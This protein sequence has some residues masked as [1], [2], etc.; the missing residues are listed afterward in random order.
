MSARLRSAALALVAVA[1]VVSVVPGA[2]ATTDV[3]RDRALA[4]VARA[5]H[6]S[7]SSGSLSAFVVARDGKT[8]TTPNSQIAVT[9]ASLMKLATTTTAV[10]KFGPAA[11]F[12]TRAVVPAA[13]DINGVVAGNLTLVGGGDPTFATGA[14]ARKFLTRKTG[15][16][17][18]STVF[19]TKLPTVELLASRVARAGVTRVNGDLVVDNYLF[20][21]SRVQRG[22]RSSYLN[23]SNGGPDVGYIDPLDVDEGYATLKRTSLT[24]SPAMRAGALLKN[25]LKERGVVVTGEVRRARAPS[26]AVELARVTSPPLG[27]I[28]WWTVKWSLNNPAEI[29]LKDIGAF[30]GARGSTAEGV[31]VVRA[32]L[33]HYNVDLSDLAMYDGSGLSLY[34]R[35]NARMIFQLIKLALRDGTA[36]GTTMRSAF[37]VALEPGTL[38]ERYGLRPLAHN[39]RGKTGNV[40]AVRCMA[41]FL[42][43]RDGAVVVYV[44]IF[45]RA[46][47]PM[48]L[49]KVLDRFGIDLAHL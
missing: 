20:D 15:M 4:A 12:A 7:A 13:P 10:A 36:T 32:T 30:Y 19:S 34:D 18:G 21:G 24:P 22:W 46:R 33:A 35:V 3:H 5:R 14:Y 27:E 25:A 48:A 23:H 42:K 43:A 49:T 26:A 37:P 9:P 17:S 11:T 45:N 44:A 16:P 29:L 28:V 6:A 8:L 38:H 41:G 2:R 39:L 31:K 40:H 1:T 47:D